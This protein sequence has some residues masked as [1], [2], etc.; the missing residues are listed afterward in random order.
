MTTIRERVEEGDISEWIVRWFKSHKDST[1]MCCYEMKKT[2]KGWLIRCHWLEVKDNIGQGWLSYDE[3]CE[4]CLK[5]QKEIERRIKDA[6]F[7][8]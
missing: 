1:P 6:G 7:D 3:F 4:T 8:C 5:C 2:V